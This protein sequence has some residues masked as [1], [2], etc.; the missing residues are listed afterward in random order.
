[1]IPVFLI[2]FGFGALVYATRSKSARQDLEDKIRKLVRSRS[3]TKRFYALKYANGDVWFA[4]SFSTNQEASDYAD[5]NLVDNFL[6]IDSEK[7]K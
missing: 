1:M 4:S 5:T 6:V 3:G 2:V 7:Y